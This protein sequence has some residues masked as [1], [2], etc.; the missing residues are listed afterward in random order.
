MSKGG[1]AAPSLQP[2]R[3]FKSSFSRPHREGLEHHNGGLKANSSPQ[4]LRLCGDWVRTLPVSRRLGS[5]GLPVEKR[6]FHHPIF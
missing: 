5:P 1:R 6:L 2:C 3:W 4:L